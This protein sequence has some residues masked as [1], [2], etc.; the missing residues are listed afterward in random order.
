[1]SAST[2]KSANWSAVA[3]KTRLWVASWGANNGTKP[4]SQPSYKYWNTWSIWQYTSKGKISGINGNVDL[5]Y[6]K[7]DA[8]IAK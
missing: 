2:T 6:A 7:A 1:M 4:V 3:A 5:D 8:W